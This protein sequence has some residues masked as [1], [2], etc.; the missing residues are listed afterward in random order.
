[1]TDGE[2]SLEIL[3][4]LIP[5][6]NDTRTLDEEDVVVAEGVG[7]NVI[8]NPAKDEITYRYLVHGYATRLI[9]LDTLHSVMKAMGV[10]D[11]SSLRLR[12]EALLIAL[13]I[14]S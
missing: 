4:I 13:R 8:F 2:L 12:C 6:E 7:A 11:K 3:R 5:W 10:T 14:G 1:M 9:S